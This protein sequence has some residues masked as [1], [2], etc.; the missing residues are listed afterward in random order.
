M[1]QVLQHPCKGITI[2][3]YQYSKAKIMVMTPVLPNPSEEIKVI[4]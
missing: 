1:T 4:L 3:L 2:Y